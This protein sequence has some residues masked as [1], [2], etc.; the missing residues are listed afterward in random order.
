MKMFEMPKVEIEEIKL[1]DIIATSVDPCDE[2]NELPC[3]T[4]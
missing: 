3:I 2:N 1:M 4:D